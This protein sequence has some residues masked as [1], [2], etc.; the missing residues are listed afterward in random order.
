M[1][2][3]I[4]G[5]LRQA[6]WA[7]ARRQEIAGD[8]S[9]RRYLRLCA[10]PETAVLMIA[11]PA[12]RAA[13][14]S[15]QAM[16][17][18][19]TGHG[20]SAPHVL[21]TAPETGLMLLED[22]GDDLIARRVADDP[23]G[24]AQ[25]YTAA[26]DLS[27]HL[28]GLPPPPDLPRLTPERMVGM[29]AVTFEQM[30]SG[31]QPNTLRDQISGPLFTLLQSHAAGP[32]VTILRD[33]HG[34]NLIWLPDRTGHAR[35]GLLDFQDAVIGPAGYDLISLL[36]DARRD[37]SPALRG[38][39]IAR[40]A[41]ALGVDPDQFALRCALLSLQR[42]LRI[43]GVFARLAETHGKPGYLR[44]MPRVAGHIRRA[45]GHAGLTDLQA[46]VGLL[47]DHYTKVPAR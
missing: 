6:G 14:D 35:I 39:L 7:G 16:A 41:A 10:G 36:D 1:N 21:A 20:L 9:A 18:Y 42:N 23:P 33:Y 43:L 5:F 40:Q 38:Q 45:A 26:A 46:P 4:Q 12:D 34:E 24:E 37:V 30:P 32:G 22:L 17:G 3:D 44:H 29:I 25:L 15:F 13:C 27:T 2:V 31:A 8:A 47:L 11:P 19:L 28:A